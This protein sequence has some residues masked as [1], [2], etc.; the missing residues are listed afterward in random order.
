[1]VRSII[2]SEKSEKIQMI[3]V[4]VPLNYVKISIKEE[5]NEQTHRRGCYNLDC[6]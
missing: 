2:L 3:M 1:M 5:A 4:F 6:F